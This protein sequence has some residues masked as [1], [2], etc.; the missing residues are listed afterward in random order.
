MDHLFEMQKM[1]KED[2]EA[3]FCELSFYTGPRTLGLLFLKEA[4]I[5]PT[6]NAKNQ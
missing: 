4:A 6:L 2:R 3:S 5:T 1:R